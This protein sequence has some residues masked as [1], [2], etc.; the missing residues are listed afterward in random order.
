MVRNSMC[1]KI[2]N[3]DV[4]R[5]F[6]Q[7]LTKTAEHILMKSY[8]IHLPTEKFP[9]FF[10]Y[11]ETGKET[12]LLKFDDN[13]DIA[14]FILFATGNTTENTQLLDT[15]FIGICLFVCPQAVDNLLRIFH[16]MRE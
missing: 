12:G 4:N 2:P 1:S 14:L 6:L 9:Q 11:A 7:I 15:V 13:I 10:L 8:Q 5:I 3:S 16:N